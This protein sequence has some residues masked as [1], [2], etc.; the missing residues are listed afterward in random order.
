MILHWI[1]WY[2]LLCKEI[3]QNK[4]VLDAWFFL[5][6]GSWK[7]IT[8]DLCCSAAGHRGNCYCRGF[9]ALASWCRLM[10]SRCRCTSVFSSLPVGFVPKGVIRSALKRKIS[11]DVVKCWTEYI[12]ISNAD[13]ASGVP[14]VSRTVLSRPIRVVKIAEAWPGYSNG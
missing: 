5:A 10:T 13:I 2:V 8:R 11:K 9:G 4:Y 3:S 6:F 7:I 12:H 14:L 1:F